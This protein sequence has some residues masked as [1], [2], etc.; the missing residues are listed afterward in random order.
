MA[1]IKT[2]QKNGVRRELR[3]I[4]GHPGIVGVETENGADG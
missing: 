3:T 1:Q 2:K 4:S